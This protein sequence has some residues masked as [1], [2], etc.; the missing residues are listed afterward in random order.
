MPDPVLYDLAE[1][2]GRALQARGWML[3]TAESCTGGWVAEAMTMIPGSSAWFDRAFVTY[4]YASKREMLGV[5]QATLDAHGAVSQAVVE[6]MV[7]GALE[8]SDARV[9]LAVSGTAGPSG[10]T[11]EKPVGTVWFAWGVKGAAPRSETRRFGGD[12]ENVRRESVIHALETLIAIIGAAT[13]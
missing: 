10:G 1:R 13:T 9:A 12:R 3:A 11:A 6:Q 8:R 5:T 4:T 2:A 7:A